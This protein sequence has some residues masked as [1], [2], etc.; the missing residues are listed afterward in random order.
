MAKWF[1]LVFH[2][3]DG[4]KLW[5]LSVPNSCSS[6]KTLT[7]YIPLNLLPYF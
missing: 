6:L 1:L 7:L 5:T 3:W 2:D 4:P